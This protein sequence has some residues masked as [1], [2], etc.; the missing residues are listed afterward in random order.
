MRAS[1]RH[2][3][4]LGAIVGL[5][6]GIASGSEIFSVQLSVTP[7]SMA[8]ITYG[9]DIFQ[10]DPVFSATLMSG[11]TGV[12][13]ATVE[14]DGGIVTAFALDGFTLVADET[15]EA[16]ISDGATTASATL[17][18]LSVVM[19][20]SGDQTFFSPGFSAGSNS[21]WGYAPT[22]GF[23][24]M[25]TADYN[26]FP[27]GSFDLS[28]QTAEFPFLNG[29][30]RVEGDTVIVESTAFIQGGDFGDPIDQGVGNFAYFGSLTVNAQGV[31][32]TPG[33]AAILSAAGLLIAASR[34][35]A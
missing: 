10:P 1:R 5:S 23:T 24:G 30:V 19:L 17:S 27:L 14:V 6:C 2:V 15:L 12:I 20:E 29:A 28:E 21:Q 16:S 22:V 4:A 34:R 35:R 33:S 8:E 32:P 26:G 9:I 3:G 7:E 18:D 31:I 13:D 11:I 25:L